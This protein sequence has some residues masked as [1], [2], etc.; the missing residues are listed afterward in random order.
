MVCFLSC[1]WVRLEIPIFFLI[2]S[3]MK[4]LLRI[5]MALRIKIEN[6]I[7]II[8]IYFGK[9]PSWINY[10]LNSCR[11]NFTIKWLV[12]S[13][14]LEIESVPSNV[15]IKKIS[16]ADYTR[17]VNN[18]LNVNFPQQ[19]AYKL[20]DIKPMLG[21]IHQDE[22]ANYDYWGFGDIDVVY[23]DLRQYYQVLLNKY[24]CIPI[25]SARISG[26]LCLLKNNKKMREAFKLV[27]G[28]LDD[29]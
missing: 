16:F 10:F 19:S 1:F 7:C 29:F 14:Y 9:W 13:D 28:L 26:H 11:C 12:Y 5:E 4:P 8:I 21:Y 18:K 17:L 2:V 25:H 20:C 23:G 27:S 24:Q 3:E 15:N 22:I 6:S